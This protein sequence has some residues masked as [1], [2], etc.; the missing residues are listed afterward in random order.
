[1]KFYNHPW[2][3]RHWNESNIAR[4]TAYWIVGNAMDVL[5]TG[6]GIFRFGQIEINP[7]ANALGW[8]LMLTLK[9]V[10]T[11]TVPLTAFGVVYV[12]DRWRRPIIDFDIAVRNLI[13]LAAI[14]V[15]AAVV[16]NAIQIFIEI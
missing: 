12:I 9:V 16:W 6:I 7:L 5:V 13:R 1:M 2:E 15:W 10:M 14:L 11:L 3:I 4:W 8:P